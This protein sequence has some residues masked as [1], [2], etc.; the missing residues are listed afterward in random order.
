MPPNTIA[1]HCSIGM[2][3]SIETTYRNASANGRTNRAMRNKTSGGRRATSA[4]LEERRHLAGGA[5]AV[6]E[7]V[8]LLDRHLRE[9]LRVA[10]REE[11]R[12]EPETAG[13][14]GFERDGPAAFPAERV[15]LPRHPEHEDGLEPRGA[16]LRALQEAEHAREPEG[17]VH[18][19]RVD[20]GEALERVDVEAGVVDEE[21]EVRLLREHLDGVRG[22]LLARVPL[23]LRQEEVEVLDLDALLLQE[24]RDLAE[25]ARVG[26]YEPD[27]LSRPRSSISA[28]FAIASS[29][30]GYASRYAARTSSN[31]ARRSKCALV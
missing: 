13:P 21:V 3:A 9:R 7:R 1:C 22:D 14:A 31:R 20:A 30:R 25:L 8:L 16:P 27:P 6:G 29:A 15:R 28:S 12:V 2:T 19:R 10:V 4:P 24:R 23:D 26:G 5:R 11:D 17:A 18:V